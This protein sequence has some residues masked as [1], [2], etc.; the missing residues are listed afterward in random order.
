MIRIQC[1]CKVVNTFSLRRYAVP[2]LIELPRLGSLVHRALDTQVTTR[3]SRVQFPA[4]ATNTGMGDRFR[5]GKLA[6][7]LSIGVFLY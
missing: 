6:N 7:H 1:D 4:A 3:W 2:V 5:A